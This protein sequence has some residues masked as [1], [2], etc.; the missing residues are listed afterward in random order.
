MKQTKTKIYSTQRNINIYENNNLMYP[1]KSVL[2]QLSQLS[3]TLRYTRR[4]FPLFTSQSQTVANL[5]K[6]ILLTLKGF[7]QKRGAEPKL[8]LCCVGKVC[9]VS[10]CFMYHTNLD[11]L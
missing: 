6:Q 7:L 9:C 3:N 5:I 8:K 10:I 1:Q 11:R 4:N 2:L